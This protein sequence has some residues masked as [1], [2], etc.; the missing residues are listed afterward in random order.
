M[1]AVVVTRAESAAKVA[2]G[3]SVALYILGLVIVSSYLGMIGIHDFSVIHARYVLTG[4]AFVFFLTLPAAVLIVSVVAARAVRRRWLKIT[5]VVVAFVLA[6]SAAGGLLFVQYD[7]RQFFDPAWSLSRVPWPEVFH[8]WRIYFV[9]RDRYETVLTLLVLVYTPAFALYVTRHK[10]FTAWY[11]VCAMLLL[12]IGLVWTGLWYTMKHYV[13]LA[14]A[15]GGGH[16][17]HCIIVLD[18]EATQALVVIKDV[19]AADRIDAFLIHESS[20]AFFFSF[21]GPYSGVLPSGLVRVRKSD[22]LLLTYVDR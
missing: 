19:E 22:L 10:H 20:D 17:G 4:S 12:A 2:G 7:Q 6:A 14:G 15:F 5:V 13:S 16:L 9:G 8:G 11:R 3:V 21:D 1:T 18:S